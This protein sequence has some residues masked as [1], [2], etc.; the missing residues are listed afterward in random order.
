MVLQF[1]VIL[2]AVHIVTTRTMKNALGTVLLQCN[3]STQRQTDEY[4]S[5]KKNETENTC[6]YV[7]IEKE[8]L[9]ITCS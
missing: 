5:R 3:K 7:M 9:A 6:K 4:A 8:A 2:T 1:C